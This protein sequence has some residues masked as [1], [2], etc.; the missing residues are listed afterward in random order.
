MSLQAVNT[1]IVPGWWVRPPRGTLA[2]PGRR[3]ASLLGS[4]VTLLVAVTTTVSA[5]VY[6]RYHETGPVPTVQP[7]DV[8]GLF[9]DLTPATVQVTREWQKFSV[10]MPRYQFLEAGNLWRQ[11]HFEDWDVLD[12]ATRRAG[13]SR[14]LAVHGH[15]V[16]DPALWRR[17]TAVEWDD[18]PQPVRAMAIVGMIEH[19]VRYYDVGAGY[20][21]APTLVV[22]TAKAIAMSES[23][24]DHRAIHINRDGSADVGVG[25]ASSFAR[26]T[27]RR[28]FEAEL[29]DFTLR[30]DEYA[31]PWL[32]SR[33]LAFWLR[34]SL[35]EAGGDLDLATRAYNVGIG[36]A[37]RGYGQA[38]LTGVEGRRERYFEGPSNSPTWSVLSQ[39]RRDQLW[40]PRLVVRVPLK[41]RAAWQ[42]P[43]HG[44]AGFAAS[45]PSESTDLER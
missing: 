41:V 5:H 11:M 42:W 17:M 12:A 18:V 32:A 45:V 16:A 2:A 35:D 21:L 24:F 34:L 14:L 28:L 43:E 40:L 37:L 25:G 26:E 4:A 13:L 15:L 8:F 44:S 39:Y 10:T 20:G 38:Y 22:R 19:W 9:V 1:A 29:A 30:D 27:L 31:N 3:V 23:W 36:R 7:L 6:A 33:W